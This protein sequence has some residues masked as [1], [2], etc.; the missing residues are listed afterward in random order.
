M[1]QI[2]ADDGREL[3]KEERIAIL[4][5]MGMSRDYAQFVVALDDGKVSGDLVITNDVSKSQEPRA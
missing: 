1:A 5:G 2:T 4:V 3:T